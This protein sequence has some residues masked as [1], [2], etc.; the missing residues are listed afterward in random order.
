MPLDPARLVELRRD[1]ERK[2]SETL[3]KPVGVLQL[4]VFAMPCGCVGVSIEVRNVVREDI[5]VF[6]P[7]VGPLVDETVRSVFGREPDVRYARTSPTGTDVVSIAGRLTCERCR[8]EI[9]SAADLITF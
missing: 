9:P 3:A 5:E 7:R 2:M 4:T 8:D 6:G 1:V